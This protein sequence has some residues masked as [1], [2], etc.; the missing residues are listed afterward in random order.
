MHL[1]FMI[2]DSSVYGL[3][4]ELLLAL[5]WINFEH[6]PSDLQLL[7]SGSLYDNITA[8][9]GVVSTLLA[10]DPS[11]SGT[12]VALELSAP[13]SDSPSILNN[14][15]KRTSLLTMQLLTIRVG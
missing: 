13:S 2:A 11:S 8:L 5:Q 4:R 10:P 15:L 3:K 6:H 1:S 12:Q 7:F 14:R 9:S